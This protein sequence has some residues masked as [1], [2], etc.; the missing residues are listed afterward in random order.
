MRDPGRIAG[1]VIIPNAVQ[2]RLLWT[3]PNGKTVANVLHA[4]VAGGF[5][6][7]STVAEAVRAAIVASAGWT[8]WKARL[9][10]TVSLAAV[11]IR[12][13]RTGNNPLVASTGA[14]AAGT[15][16]GTALPPGDALVVTLRTAFAGRSYRGRA[17]LPGL[18]STALAAGGVAAAGTVTDATSFMTAVQTALSGQGMT[19]AVAQPARQQYTSAKGTLHNARTAALQTVT[20]IVT[21]NTTIDHQR[22]RAG[23]S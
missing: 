21:R 8:A 15:G 23:R 5:S 20:S 17:Y 12:D 13:L 4:S 14:A 6:A 19:L 11:D 18:D 22:R 10:T 2:V 9:N 7:T 1:P 16:A 3:L